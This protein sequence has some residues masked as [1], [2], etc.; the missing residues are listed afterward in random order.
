MKSTIYT[1][2]LENGKYYVGRT[3]VPKQR[4]L[5]HFQEEGSKWTK[6]HKPVRILSQVKGDE[7]DEEKYTLIAMENYS[8]DNV[9]GGSYCKI[10]LPQHEKDKALQTIRSIT[11]KCYKCGKKGHFAKDCNND[12]FINNE[13]SDD[14]IEDNINLNIDNK[15]CKKCGWVHFKKNELCDGTYCGA[16]G[17][18]GESY[19][20]DDCYGACFECCCIDCGKKNREC[21]CRKCE[22]C[23]EIIMN[24]EKHICP[25]LCDNCNKSIHWIGVDIDTSCK[26]IDCNKYISYVSDVSYHK[27]FNCLQHWCT[28]CFNIKKR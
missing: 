8:I 6:L 21:L 28:D 15:H 1:L 16:C 27:C 9:R 20:S 11:D 13:D 26:C 18:S 14:D 17:G 2:E 3:N 19:W 4:I 22:T 10:E 24:N 12:N 7:F 25:P 23:K 5:K